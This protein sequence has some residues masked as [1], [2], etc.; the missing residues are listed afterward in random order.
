MSMLRS[1]DSAVSGLRNHQVRMDIIGNNIAN[2]N[3]IGFKTSRLTFEESLSQLLQGSTRPPGESGGTNPIQVGLGMGV[4]SIDT[5]FSQGNLE[6]TGQTTDLAIEGSSF[7]AVANGEETFYTRNGAFQLDAKGSLVLPTNGFVVQGKIADMEGNFPPGTVIEDVKIPLNE[8]APAHATENITFGKNLDSDAMALGTVDNSQ[9]FMHHA[10]EADPL[11]SMRDSNGNLLGLEIGDVLTISGENPSDGTM[12]TTEF[13]VTD[14]STLLDLTT[15]MESFIGAATGL[16][17]AGTTV[18]VV[19]AAEDPANRGAI[20]IH[21]NGFSPILNFGVSSSNTLNAAKVENAFNVTTTIPQSA[22]PLAYMTNALRAPARADDLLGEIYSA[23]GKDMGLQNGDEISVT[24]EVGGNPANSST[25]LL[26][27]DTTTTMAML[28]DTIRDT[29]QLPATDGTLQDNPTVG[30]NPTGSNDNIADG[31]I[32]VRGSAGNDFRLSNMAVTA[33]NANNQNPAPVDFNTNMSFNHVRDSRDPQVSDTS[34]TV[35]DESGDDHIMT[36]TYIPT[37]IPGNWQWRISMSGNELPLEGS[38]G[39]LV[40]AQDGTVASFTFEQGETQFAFDPNNG[41]GIVRVRLDVGGPG[42]F[43][44]LTQFRAPTTAAATQ[45]DGFTTG[46]LRDI[47]IGE[48]GVISGI[49][50]NGVKKPL[51]QIMLVDFINPGGLMKVSDSVFTKTSNSGEAVWVTAGNDRTSKIKP[52]ALEI[53]NVELALEFT[54]MITTQRGYQA[55][56]RGVSISDSL[57]EEL[58]N[59]KR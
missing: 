49:F 27:S 58:V 7:F 41:S 48:A 5:K 52:G 30:I 1:L 4:G 24:G 19:T 39:N 3:T 6:A 31:A 16:G 44:G 47:S 32:V 23:N 54:E 42:D 53:S 21:G 38:Q 25:S 20:Q 17:N 46:E 14:T 29:F 11:T 8:Q 37:Q 34:I 51:A 33:S 59:L 28:M 9:V 10:Q 13:N 18:A 12:R 15:A 57:L 2:I 50:T 22:A 26:Y 35:F 40:F 45:Q 56:A 43:G 36:M 55:N